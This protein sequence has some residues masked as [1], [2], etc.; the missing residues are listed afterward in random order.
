MSD[1]DAKP[2][3]L[4]GRPPIDGQAGDSW[5]QLRTTGARKGAYVR[6]AHGRNMKLSQWVFEQLDRA[7]GYTPG[8]KA[9]QGE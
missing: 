1:S 3:N 7:A 4:G 5:I 2:K 6:A 9:H 8:E